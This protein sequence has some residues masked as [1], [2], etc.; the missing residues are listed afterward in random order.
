MIALT[1]FLFSSKELYVCAPFSEKGSPLRFWFMVMQKEG[2]VEIQ[3]LVVLSN[4]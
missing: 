1:R 4:N 3:G 2:S